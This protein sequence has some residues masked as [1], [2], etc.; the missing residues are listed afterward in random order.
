MTTHATLKADIDTWLA[1]ND[2]SGSASVATIV[3]MCEAEIAR[4]VRVRDQIT[5]GTVTADAR[6]TTL[7]TGYLALRS[8]TLDVTNGRSLDFMTSEAIRESN[9]WDRSSGNPEAF[10]ID[11]NSIVWAP[12]PSS[13]LTADIVYFKRYDAFSEDSDTN[14]ILSN[15]YD[16]YLFCA[17]KNA[18]IYLQDFDG[19]TYYNSKVTEK[20]EELKP[21]QLRSSYSG[22]AFVANANPRPIV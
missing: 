15:H 20:L 14:Y 19:E 3:T 11:G 18:C 8:L 12:A 1:R 17:L 16:I 6:T 22:S 21:D 13:S 7:P 2:I 10:T 9:I 5:I 4:V